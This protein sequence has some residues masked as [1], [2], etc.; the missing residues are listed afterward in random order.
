MLLAGFHNAAPGFPFSGP[1]L[2]FSTAIW[3]TFLQRLMPGTVVPWVSLVVFPM[4]AYGIKLLGLGPM[5]RLDL[6]EDRHRSVA[7]V[8]AL[9][10]ALSFVI[11]T[12]FP[13]Q[14]FG[15]VGIVFLQPTLWILGLFSLRP[16]YAWMEQGRR[17]WRAIA[18]WG[19]L[20]LTWV[21][22]LGAFN[23]SHKVA[24][25][26]DTARALQ[27]IRLTAAAED[28]VAYLP[29]ELTATPIWGS[30]PESTNFAI[31]AMTG[32]DGYF[33]SEPYSKYFAVPGLRGS[34]PADVL[35]QAE[36]LYEQ[37]RDDVGS[38]VK[39]D[40]DDAASARL[41]KDHVQWIVVWGDAVQGISTTTTPWRKTREIA[42]YRVTPQDN[43]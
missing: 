3:G 38:F 4:V 13:Y 23:F 24:F 40:I 8:F 33:S 16:V 26:P 5:A 14:A 28:V 43:F 15:G 10:F 42:V 22:A 34:D 6:G 12:F 25:D 21:Q 11:G 29:S 20:G 17:S 39:G 35:A 36:R 7:L 30:A 2:D 9:A 31:T 1:N 32:L 37:R 18:L 27:D 19:I 41:A